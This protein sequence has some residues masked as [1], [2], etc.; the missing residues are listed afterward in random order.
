MNL[1]GLVRILIIV[2]VAAFLALVL[3][4]WVL[5][6]AGLAS[7]LIWWQIGVVLVAV[8]LILQTIGIA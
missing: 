7:G 5:A 2:A 1:T 6:A 3:G 4:P 8:Y